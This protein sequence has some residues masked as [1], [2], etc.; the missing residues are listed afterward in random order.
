MTTVTITIADGEDGV[1]NLEGRVDDPS[2]A[3]KVPTGALIVASY[4]AANAEHICQSAI[5]WFRN[6]IPSAGDEQ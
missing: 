4:I 5:K 1:V 2:V 3:N 6:E